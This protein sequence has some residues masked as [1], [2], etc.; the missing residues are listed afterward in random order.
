MS[1]EIVEK[2][3]GIMALLIVLVV[4]VGGLVEIVPLFALTETT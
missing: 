1:H 2:N 4:S 3:T